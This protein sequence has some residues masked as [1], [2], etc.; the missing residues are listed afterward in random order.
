MVNK[1]VHIHAIHWLAAQGQCYGTG[2]QPPAKLTHPPEA[3]LLERGNHYLIYAQLFRKIKL[4]GIWVSLVSYT[5]W[6]WSVTYIC[7]HT[8]FLHK[9]A[10]T[11]QFLLHGNA[12][13]MRGQEVAGSREVVWGWTLSCAISC[14]G[15]RTFFFSALISPSVKWQSWMKWRWEHSLFQ[16]ELNLRKLQIEFLHGIPVLSATVLGRMLQDLGPSVWELENLGTTL[17]WKF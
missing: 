10:N 16:I 2:L 17:Y 15:W 7:V 4:Q 8:L 3:D 6:S 13:Q 1:N 11:E 14:P 9:L 5:V 12:S